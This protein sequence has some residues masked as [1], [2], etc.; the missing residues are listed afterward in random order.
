MSQENKNN[1]TFW[2]DQAANAQ[3]Q[4]SSIP[5]Y[6]TAADSSSM[7]Q[8]GNQ[9]NPDPNANYSSNPVIP[10]TFSNSQQ[11][12][13]NSF[14][15]QPD[16]FSA[17]NGPSIPMQNEQN[18]F[19]NQQ[20][21][22]NI[23]NSDNF[24]YNAASNGTPFSSYQTPPPVYPGYT[25]G[26]IPVEPPKK[27][28]NKAAKKALKFVGSAALFGLV[29]GG[30]FLGFN[31]IYY[32]FNPESNPAS[33]YSSND[34]ANQLQIPNQKTTLPTTTVS[35][36]VSI[37]ETDVS[38]IVEKTM[39]ATVAIT[40]QFVTRNYFYGE[41]TQEGGGSGIIIGENDT[42]YLIATNNHVVE[43]AS[44]ITIAFIDGNTAQAY[45]KGRDSAADLAVIAVKKDSISEDTKNAIAIATLGN[46][47]EVKVGNMV[48]AI[49]NALGNGQSTTVGW[50][51][52][53]DREITNSDTGTT[54]TV[55][56]TD[57]A[58]NP[59][60][61]GG[62]LLN[63]KGE[64]IGINSAKLT[65]TK[66]EGIGYAIP[67]SKALPIV[68]DLMNREILTEDEKGYLGIQLSDVDITA[69]IAA[70]YNWPMGVYIKS[71]YPNSGS[72]KAGLMAGDII[73]AV[74]GVAITTRAQLQEK[75][76]SYRYGTSITI[77]YSRF[78]D[79]IY[80]EYKTD[81]VLSSA[82]VLNDSS[83]SSSSKNQED[84]SKEDNNTKRSKQKDSGNLNP[85][86]QDSNTQDPNT[87]VP[88]TQTPDAQD[89]NALDPN[90][91]VPNTQD[92][93]TQIPKSEDSYN[94]FEN[95]FEDFF[96]TPFGR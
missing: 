62:A 41:Y 31:K 39:P 94:P 66:I 83:N 78:E 85:D 96:G 38:A 7:N 6:Q 58:I 72:E 23:N 55:L 20:N 74:N 1:Y 59:G 52:A 4:N 46:S 22:Q 61:S 16:N 28:S 60:N 76:T 8:T 80:K 64:V 26:A 77:T 75:I 47:E 56:Q 42:E 54:M 12:G 15:G 29:A 24:A 40:S 27:K 71:V 43:N 44:E 81:V 9:T 86:T 30:T 10:P 37:L 50:I 69:E 82:S 95:F 25:N 14:S 65:G 84:S 70:A 93:N 13:Q 67:I 68:N 36:N 3:S 17:V 91:L 5:P 73:T 48:I 34:L 35:N 89:P 88:D 2:A 19:S 63:M 11:K 21:R 92:P 90:T 45:I 49:G 87:Q 33:S 18:A 53:K 32:H 57:A 79:G 51:S